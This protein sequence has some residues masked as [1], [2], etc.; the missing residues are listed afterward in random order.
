[1]E[2]LN[3]ILSDFADINADEYVSNNY[4]LSIMSESTKENIFEIAIKATFAT[5]NDI[6]EL[7]QLKDWK[8]NS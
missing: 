3:K 5:R 4:E 1:M 7:I 2:K 8:K 6:L